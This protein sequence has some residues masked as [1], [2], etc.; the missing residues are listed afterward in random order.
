MEDN[1]KMDIGS[2][3]WRDG[4]KINIEKIPDRFSAKLKRGKKIEELSSSQYAPHKKSFYRQHIDEFSVD[5]AM[6]D[7]VMDRVR[8]SGEVEFASHV[9]SF[10]TDPQSNIYITDELTVQFKP[11]VTNQGVEEIVLDL[12]LRLV[13]QVEGL[14]NTFVFSVTSQAKMNPVKLSNLLM[15]TG[16]VLVSEPNILVSTKP[17]Y[18]PQDSLFK[19]Q[20][21]LNHNGGPFLSDDAHV[22]AIKAWDI[23]RGKRSVTIA[24]IDDSIDMNHID[25]QGEEKIVA[26][27][28]FAGRDFQPLP[29]NEDDNHGTACAGVAVAEENGNGVVGIAPGCSLM[30]IRMSGIDDNSIESLFGWAVEKGASVIS[31]SWGPASRNY[32]LSLRQKNALRLAL[33]N[34]RNGLGC[35]IVFAAG[36]SNRPVKGVVYEQDW[37]DRQLQGNTYWYDGFASHENILTVSSCTSQANKA[38]YSNW[39]EEINV[40]APSSNAPPD[41]YPLVSDSLPGWGVV[42]TDRVGPGGY[43][44]ADYTGGF[45]GTSSSCPLVAGV[46]GLIISA[47]PLLTEK[48]VRQIIEQ[49]TDKIEDNNSD[50]QLKNQYGVYDNNGHSKWFGY[51]KVNAF[52]AVSEAIKRRNEITFSLQQESTPQLHIPDNNVAGIVD[53][54]RFNEVGSIVEINV[55]VEIQHTYIGDLVVSLNSPAGTVVELQKRKG[56]SQQNLNVI[57]D[58]VNTA[59]LLVLEGEGLFGDWLLKVQD[60]ASIDEGLLSRWSLAIKARSKSAIILSQ[61]ESIKIPDNNPDGIESV[62]S[63][64]V[65]GTIESISVLIDVSHTYI[66]DLIVTLISPGG[67]NVVLHQQEGWEADNIKQSYDMTNFPLLKNMAGEK[68]AGEWRLKIIDLAFQDVG[69][70]NHWQLEIVREN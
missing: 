16:K 38:A 69:K 4:K 59:S 23:E 46:A 65:P 42:T 62:I 25:F 21:H 61:N 30:P 22:D 43:S 26:P 8:Q 34:G 15:D 11:E 63:T 36:N 13:K 3:I 29:E 48:D 40:C 33:A 68:I 6:R 1:N 49:T 28:D 27:V 44:S 58:S 32:P 35:V 19:Y 20:W 31:C 17:H 51:G 54:I 45:G 56:G 10:S 7:T 50:P 2:Y 9:Y 66:G 60:L 53:S 12:G 70:L 47:N 67:R 41:T 18:V 24:I 5:A 37:P 55:E 52:K 14:E 39:G 57:Y 64:D